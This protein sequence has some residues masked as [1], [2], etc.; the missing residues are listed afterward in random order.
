MLAL[1]AV[2]TVLLVVAGDEVIQV[3]PLEGAF[4]KREMQVRAEVIDPKFLRPRLLLS[5]FYCSKP[6]KASPFTSAERLDHCSLLIG[7]TISQA[8][9]GLGLGS[10]SALCGK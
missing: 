6:S 3:A 10:C 7:S 4:L 5:A 2:I 1:L 8:E 9:L